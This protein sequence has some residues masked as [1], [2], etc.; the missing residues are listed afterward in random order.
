MRRFGARAAQTALAMSVLLGWAA[1][2]HAGDTVTTTITGFGTVGGTFTSDSNYAY[3]HDVSE[4]NGAA[5]QFD[6][7]LESRIGVQAVFDFGSNVSVTAQ[8]VARHRGNNDFALG[9]EWL[10]AQYAPAPD[11][12]LR[13]GRVELA[14]FLISDSREVGYAATWFRA[15]NEIYGSEPFNYVDGGQMLWRHNVGQAAVGL[16]ASYGNTA[17][18]F[19]V[20]GKSVDIQSKY[21]V[22]ASATFEYGNLLLRVAHTTLNTPF[23]VPLSA[24]RSVTYNVKDKY[25][26]VGIQYDDGRAIVLGEWAKRSE[27]VGPG[28]PLPLTASTQGYA[29]A[30]WHVG[31]LT[32]MLIYG[33]NKPARSLLTPAGDY[34]T[35]SAVLRYDMARNIAL[36]MEVSR[37]SAHAGYFVTPNYTSTAHVNVYSVGA[38]FVF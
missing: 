33:L 30:G 25:L 20:Q 18:K 13:V 17:Q 27:N 3:R 26:S 32:P 19:D 37:P 5:N 29:A 10:Y 12:K 24:T 31:K 34:G 28:L 15:P 1:R 8:E 11:W 2:V 4:F 35:W 7:G 23:T 21:V 38:D 22:N 16:Q 14:T 6:V 36:K 9:A